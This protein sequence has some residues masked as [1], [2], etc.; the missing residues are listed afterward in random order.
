MQNMNHGL[1]AYN[2]LHWINGTCLVQRPCS[3]PSVC[4]EMDHRNGHCFVPWPNFSNAQGVEQNG[5]RKKDRGNFLKTQF[6]LS[7]ANTLMA[8]T[9]PAGN[10]HLRVNWIQVHF[11]YAFTFSNSVT[12]W[13][14][15]SHHP[16]SLRSFFLSSSLLLHPFLAQLN[17]KSY[18]PSFQNLALLLLLL[19]LLSRPKA[20]SSF[21][22]NERT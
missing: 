15:H 19:Q 20:C 9:I 7:E 6:Y 11:S 21:H 18:F 12:N 2:A 8:S 1:N 13:S 5:T 14:Q 22:N 3:I 16:G 10:E 17:S 4:F